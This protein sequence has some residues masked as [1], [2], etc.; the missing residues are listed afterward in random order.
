MRLLD[1]TK[2]VDDF[3]EKLPP[4]QFKQVYSTI[5]DLRR[6]VMP[7]DA[8]KLHGSDNQYRVDIGEYRVIYTFDHKIVYVQA[9]GKRN[10]GE[11]Y[12]K[13]KK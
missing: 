2:Q 7:H 8:I 1:I 9:V 6:N 11:V 4:K 3:L 13:N 12:K 5:M 10:D